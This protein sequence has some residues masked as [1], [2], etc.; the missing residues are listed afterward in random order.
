M[1]ALPS[2]SKSVCRLEIEQMLNPLLKRRRLARQYPSRCE[3]NSSC[4]K[5]KKKL[6]GAAAFTHHRLK[7]GGGGGG[8]S[9][10]YNNSSIK[11]IYIYIYIY[12]HQSPRPNMI[13]PLLC[14]ISFSIFH[15]MNIHNLSDPSNTYPKAWGK[16]RLYY[17]F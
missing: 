10:F 6:R 5:Q 2:G 1:R 16:E 3:D 9:F 8:T 17:Y 14:L 15:G 4:A 11:S 13:D 12:I 7:V